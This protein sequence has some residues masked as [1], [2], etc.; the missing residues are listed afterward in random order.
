M[1]CIFPDVS[2]H[3]HGLSGTWKVDNCGKPSRIYNIGQSGSQVG[4]IFICLDI[5]KPS[6]HHKNNGVIHVWKVRTDCQIVFVLSRIGNKS[7]ILVET[8]FCESFEMLI[9]VPEDLMSHMNIWEYPRYWRCL[10]CL[11]SINSTFEVNY[12]CPYMSMIFAV[13]HELKPLPIRV[14]LKTGYPKGTPKSTRWWSFVI[15]YLTMSPF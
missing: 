7:C 12:S 14:R 15:S 4:Y 1:V 8:L 5:P 3:F 2:R 9:W 11:E 13:E 6:F 10:P